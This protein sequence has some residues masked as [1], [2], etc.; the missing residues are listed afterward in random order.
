MDLMDKKRGHILVVEDDEAIS[1]LLEQ[2]LK[3][4]D[5]HV[6]RAG[7]G[8]IALDILKK[9]ET[10]PDIVI[11]DLT[12]PIMDGAEF[13]RLQLQDPRLATIPVIL[14]SAENQISQIVKELHIKNTLKKPLSIDLLLNSVSQILLDK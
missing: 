13:R 10:L 12:M 14:M 1:S 4:D 8:R 6:E 5:H 9:S 7:N 11:L 2:V 3:I